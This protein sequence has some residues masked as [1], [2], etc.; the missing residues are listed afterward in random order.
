M[1]PQYPVTN[2]K[3][4]VARPK[5]LYGLHPA[6]YHGAT[7]IEAEG[8]CGGKRVFQRRAYCRF[9]DGRLRVV[10]CTLPDTAFTI[11]GRLS[12]QGILYHGYISL[13]TTTEELIFTVRQ[14][15]GAN[16]E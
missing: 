5:T 2:R 13:D 12:I 3:V 11:P 14:P 1:R 15:G 7:W 4:P 8:F 9:P 10:R 16:A 6:T